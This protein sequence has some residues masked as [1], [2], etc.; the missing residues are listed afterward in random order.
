MPDEKPSKTD[1]DKTKYGRCESRS[2]QLISGRLDTTRKR[3]KWRCATETHR[4]ATQT[5]DVLYIKRFPAQSCYT[6]L[7]DFSCRTTLCFY[8]RKKSWI[9]HELMN[10]WPSWT[11][12]RAYTSRQQD[13]ISNRFSFSDQTSFD[14]TR[15]RVYWL[16]TRKDRYY[17]WLVPVHKSTQGCVEDD[18]KMLPSNKCFKTSSALIVV[19]VLSTNRKIGPT[20]K[21]LWAFIYIF[22]CFFF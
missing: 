20:F 1:G 6:R 16:K 12:K 11:G 3:E 7:V 5:Q 22:G 9:S 17:S 13:L 8:D 15:A 10:I 2:Y 18:N 4:G 21:R 19:V 14:K